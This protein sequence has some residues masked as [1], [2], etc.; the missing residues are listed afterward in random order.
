MAHPILIYM[1]PVCNPYVTKCD[2]LMFVTGL[3]FWL[4]QNQE[5]FDHILEPIMICL[6]P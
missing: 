2:D 5:T 1:Y 4:I 3:I 6:I